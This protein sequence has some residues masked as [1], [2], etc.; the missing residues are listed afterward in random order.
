MALAEGAMLGEDD[1]RLAM[2]VGDSV[3]PRTSGTLDEA[4]RAHVERT[5]RRC[6]G[7]RT[8]AA[9]ELGIDRTTLYRMLMRWNATAVAD[10]TTPSQVTE[11]KKQSGGGR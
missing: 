8:A 10:R 11:N 4:V 3:A 5:L 2:G 1:I 9:R 6:R 7:N